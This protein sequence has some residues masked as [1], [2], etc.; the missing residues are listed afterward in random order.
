[1]FEIALISPDAELHGHFRALFE[2]YRS[3]KFSWI[4]KG[5]SDACG[6]LDPKGVPDLLIVDLGP[7]R[8][9]AVSAIG[10]LRERGI[11]VAVL[12][13]SDDLDQEDVRSLLHYRATDWL[14]IM[15]GQI[16]DDP[17]V[18]RACEQAIQAHARMIEA[19]NVSR[20]VSFLAA[21]GGV[22]QSTLVAT[23]GL[24]LANRRQKS[25]NV[26]IVD[27]NFQY[28]SLADYLDLDPGLDVS[29]ISEEPQRIDKTLIEVMV[30]RHDSG[31]AL[32]SAPP[33]RTARRAEPQ[34]FVAQLLNVVSEMFEDVL[35]DLPPS[36]Q[37]WTGDILAGSDELFL[38]TDFTVPGLR[39]AKQLLDGLGDSAPARSTPK[40]IVNRCAERF[41][42]TGLRRSDAQELFG[43]A[44]AGFVSNESERVHEAINLGQMNT[45]AANSS[46]IAKDLKRILPELQAAPGFTERR[47]PKVA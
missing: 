18:I 47:P 4:A 1:M 7:K 14:R 38:V 40:V 5:I 26:C 31:L 2:A 20:C 22:G 17:E 46:R 8:S 39:R 24:L 32:L 29:A 25:R 11:Q 42:G 30:S 43:K 44:L 23:T 28:S 15:D 45:L 37:S 16:P 6:E 36:W 27:L 34:L 3:F 9:E 35:I 13:V 10:S 41:F 33:D 12:T 19:E 21:A